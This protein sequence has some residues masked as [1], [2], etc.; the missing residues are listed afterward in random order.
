MADETTNESQTEETMHQNNESESAQEVKVEVV[1]EKSENVTSMELAK[2][3]ARVAELEDQALRQRAEHEN[4]RKAIYKESDKRVGIAV[5]KVVTKFLTIMSAFNQGIQ[6][7]E[8]APDIAGVINGMKMVDSMFTA[9]LTEL[10]V[11]E[12]NAEPGTPLDPSLHMAI[13][14]QESSEH[15][16]NTIV[17]VVAKGYTY[18]GL[19]L[20]PAMVIVSA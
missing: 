18:Q 4:S 20:Q 14:K 1:D 8:Q 13:S 2:L 9:A 5:K 17:S 6:S 15:P 19:L 3:K 7:A 10:E 11:M 16:T 12:I